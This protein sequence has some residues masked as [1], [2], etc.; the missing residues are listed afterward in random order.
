MK[1]RDGVASHCK[2][3]T[4]IWNRGY[5]KTTKGQQ[6]RKVYYQKYKEK[7]LDRKLQKKF[8]ITLQEYKAK[9]DNQ[10]GRCMICGRTPAENGKALAVDH[11]HKTGVVR[12]LLCN[13]CNVC[14]GF[15][16]NSKVDVACLKQ[17]MDKHKIIN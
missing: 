1:T 8:G 9:L 13:N 7:Q 10:R 11:N 15:I 16:E 14:L 17:Y 2:V 4:A 5:T 6:Q 3:C 12:D